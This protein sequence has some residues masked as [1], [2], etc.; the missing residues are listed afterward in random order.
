M[1][2]VMKRRHA[3]Y[4]HWSFSTYQF[5]KP[6]VETMQEDPPLW[7]S[8]SRLASSGA[9]KN[10]FTS[11]AYFHTTIYTAQD[12]SKGS[13]SWTRHPSR[14]HP[15]STPAPRLRQSLAISQRNSRF[16]IRAPT[17]T[18]PP[19]EKKMPCK[20][21]ASSPHVS[22]SGANPV[23]AF[24]FARAR[25][26]QTTTL[27]PPAGHVRHIGD[28]AIDRMVCGWEVRETCVNGR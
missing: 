21:A 2:C 22:N 4:L 13:S 18:A 5:T 7:I 20:K 15:F 19:C 23:V 10:H 1:G 14:D 8:I 6:T 26:R 24:S 25:L 16:D 27:G 12:F 17:I 11:T 3:Y 9:S 28:I